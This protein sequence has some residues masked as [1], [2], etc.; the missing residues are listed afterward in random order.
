MAM[1]LPVVAA[2]AVALPHLIDDN[3]HLFQPGEVT[4]WPGT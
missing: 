1:G 3:G 4:P 2:D